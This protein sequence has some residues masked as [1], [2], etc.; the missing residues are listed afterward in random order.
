MHVEEYDSPAAQRRRCSV[1]YGLIAEIDAALSVCLHLLS[2]GL[3]SEVSAMQLM[4]PRN[5]YHFVTP[6]PEDKAIEI[7]RCFECLLCSTCKPRGD[8]Y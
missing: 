6:G 1:F 4:L 7:G 2:R 3:Q 5:L 8:A